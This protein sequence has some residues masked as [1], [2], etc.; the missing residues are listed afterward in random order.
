MIENFIRSLVNFS[1]EDIK[2]FLEKAVIREVKKKTILLKEGDVSQEV[3]FIMKGC[4]RLFYIK[5]GDEISECFFTEGILGGAHDSFISQTPSRNWLETIEDST[6]LTLSY[7]NLQLLY[8]EIP[9]MNELVRKVM[10]ERFVYLQQL[11]T[12]H[13]LDTPEQRYE[14]LVRERPDLINRVP[15]HQL[16]TFLGI[17]KVSL[18]RIRTRT[19]TREKLKKTE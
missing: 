12:S 9:K 5:D 16:A 11:F 3:F 4:I 8:S 14:K 13:I 7:T 17:T 1:D 10:E 19:K 18:S 6:L 2:K 15:Q